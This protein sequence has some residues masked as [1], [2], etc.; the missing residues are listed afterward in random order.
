[1]KKK[2]KA[3]KFLIGKNEAAQPG[4]TFVVHTQEPQFVGEIHRFDS[5]IA[6]NLFIEE[7]KEKEVIQI[8]PTTVLIVLNYFNTTVKISDKGYLENKI[9]HWIIANYLN[10]SAF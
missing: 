2:K 9:I 8:T 3:P 5:L 10:S 1:M 7:N 4:A 6:R